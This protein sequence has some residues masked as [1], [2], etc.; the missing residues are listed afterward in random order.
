MSTATMTL[1]WQ[2]RLRPGPA[3]RRV[4]LPY[5]S[6][7]LSTAVHVALGVAVVLGA[8]AWKASQPKTYVVN[9]VPAVAAVGL[10]QGT[11]TPTLPPRA[12]E[13]VTKTRTPDADAPPPAPPSEPSLPRPRETASLPDRS[14]PARAALPRAGEKELP[15]IASAPPA[16][17]PATPAPATGAGRAEP[18]AP[19]LG[20]PTGSPQGSGALTLQAGDFPYAWYLRVIERKIQE[21]W[22]QPLSSREGQHVV[23]VFEIA[24][25]GQVRRVSVEKTSGDAVY[26]QAALRAIT[27]ANP[28][29]PLPDD[30]K[31]APLRVHLGFTYNQRG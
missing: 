27:E 30:F 28:F 22:K 6:L 3:L 8:A 23:A 13:P 26:D 19:P 2:P 25:D 11:R 24:R 7:A 21:T 16:P 14:A 1:R 20:R 29:P 15:A 10:P 31:D 4:H 17:R 9:L 5:A 18:P 12:I